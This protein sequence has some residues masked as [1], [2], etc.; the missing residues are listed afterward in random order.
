ML[1]LLK[2]LIV[3]SAFATG[4]HADEHPSLKGKND[5]LCNVVVNNNWKAF[6]NTLAFHDKA[7][8]QAL[9]HMRCGFRDGYL[10]S[11]ISPLGW[12][13]IILT[14]EYRWR[15]MKVKNA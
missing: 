11:H 10:L 2:V 13:H 1:R 6:K 3:L 14:G 15:Q 8:S 12:A 7:A 4:A 5:V 9:A